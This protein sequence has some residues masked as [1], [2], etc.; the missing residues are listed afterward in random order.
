MLVNRASDQFARCAADTSKSRDGHPQPLWPRGRE[1]HRCCG[2]P[3]WFCLSFR[4]KWSQSL[5][6]S[7]SVGQWARHFCGKPECLK[8]LRFVI[9]QNVPIELI[10]ITLKRFYHV[11]LCSDLFNGE[12][13]DVDLKGVALGGFLK[14]NSLWSMTGW[15]HFGTWYVA[16]AE[17]IEHRGMHEDVSIVG[18]RFKSF[19]KI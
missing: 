9:F 13:I 3:L 1:S 18:A 16:G 5:W 2:Q 7:G 14:T 8:A 15:R 10:A 6:R 11:R 4:C 19:E 12:L 17:D